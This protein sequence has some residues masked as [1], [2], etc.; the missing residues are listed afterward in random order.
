MNHHLSTE[1][2]TAIDCIAPQ[3]EG[4]FQELNSEL[5][6]E[7]SIETLGQ[8]NTTQVSVPSISHTTQITES[9]NDAS[10]HVHV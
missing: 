8:A 5:Q 3:A 6:T 4:K 7:V 1:K 9:I 2:S 10:I